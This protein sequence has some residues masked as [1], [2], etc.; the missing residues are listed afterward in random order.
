MNFYSQFTVIR[1]NNET[2]ETSVKQLVIPYWLEWILWGADTRKD[3]SEAPA[4]GR[5]R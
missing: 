1:V 4:A 3:T 2:M 5:K